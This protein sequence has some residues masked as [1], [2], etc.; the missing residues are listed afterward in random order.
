MTLMTFPRH[1]LRKQSP[2]AGESPKLLKVTFSV[3]RILRTKN[4]HSIGFVAFY[5]TGIFYSYSCEPASF[6]A[7]MAENPIVIRNPDV[8]ILD[9][10]FL[11]T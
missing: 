3:L 8:L 6:S 2:A 9:D 10:N 5:I 1:L 11:T 7:L 4:P